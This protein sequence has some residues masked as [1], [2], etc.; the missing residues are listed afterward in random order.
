MNFLLLAFVFLFPVFLSQGIRLHASRM[1]LVC[2]NT[3][4]ILRSQNGGKLT[5]VESLF[6]KQKGNRM[7][8]FAWSELP[9]AYLSGLMLGPEEGKEWI[10]LLMLIIPR[11]ARRSP[12]SHKT[13]PEIKAAGYNQPLD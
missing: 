1:P 6:S 12:K 9:T 5:T 13:P 10:H 7:H 3:I 8:C 4:C 2:C 11:D